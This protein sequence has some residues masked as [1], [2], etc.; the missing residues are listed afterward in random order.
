MNEGIYSRRIE[1]GSGAKARAENHRTTAFAEVAEVQQWRPKANGGFELE[2]ARRKLV[3]AREG[4]K[5]AKEED[6][7]LK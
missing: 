7:G 2:Q 3:G 4:V 5:E 6:Q 1:E